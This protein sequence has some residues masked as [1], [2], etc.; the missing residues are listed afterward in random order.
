MWLHVCNRLLFS[1]CFFIGTHH[2]LFILSAVLIEGIFSK[3]IG[4]VDTA[5]LLG[6][7]FPDCFL[8]DLGPL[9]FI[10]CLLFLLGLFHISDRRCQSTNFIYQ[11]LVCDIG[12]IVLHQLFRALLFTKI[13]FG[14][15]PPKKRNNDGY[16]Q[17]NACSNIP[18]GLGGCV[19]AKHGFNFFFHFV[20]PFFAD[21]D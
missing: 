6:N 2:R 17:N 15:I 19:I 5:H 18:V 21:Q 3:T 16:H 20:L 7:D 12:G 8:V 1:Q 14:N 10:I 9:L 11:I 4:I 13:V